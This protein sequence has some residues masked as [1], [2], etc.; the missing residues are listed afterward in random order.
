MPTKYRT[1]RVHESGHTFYLPVEGVPFT[2]SVHPWLKLAIARE[3]KN[4]YRWNVIEL[5]TCYRI[6]PIDSYSVEEAEANAE[7]FL[8]SKS[9]E[10]IRDAILERLGLI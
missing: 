6:V 2:C 3:P 1:A 5:N 7:R 10:E 4:A 9:R 8:R